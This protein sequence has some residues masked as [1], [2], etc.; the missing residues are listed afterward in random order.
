M[1]ANSF[2]TVSLSPPTVLVSV[3]P[4]RMHG[5]FPRAAA[6]ASTCCRS[7]AGNCRGISPAGRAQPPCL[8]MKSWTACRDYPGAWPTS[9]ARWPARRRQR[10]HADHRRS[11]QLRL[12]RQYS[13]GVLF[14][15]LPSR[16]R[17]AVRSLMASGPVLCRQG[18]SLR[19]GHRL[20]I[21]HQAVINPHPGHL[22]RDPDVLGRRKRVAVVEG[23]QRDADHGAVGPP[24]K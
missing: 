9:P 19:S 14:Q 1:T 22:F 20:W 17:R 8:T 16:T 23:G 24:G 4:G 7:R 12:P 5:R 11:V 13:A 2:V 15:P 21:L 6:I 18:P 10:P 3:M